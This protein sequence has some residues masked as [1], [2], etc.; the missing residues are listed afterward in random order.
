[1][2]KPVAIGLFGLGN[3]GSGLVSLLQERRKGIRDSTGL[4][5]SIKAICVKDTGKQRDAALS[6]EG[7]RITGD[8][9]AIVQDPDIDVAVELMGGVEPASEMIIKALQHKKPVVTANKAALAAKG[10]EIFTAASSNGVGIFFEAAVCG[11]IPIIRV[12]QESL[13]SDSIQAMFGIINGTTN[14]ILTKMTFDSKE[15]DAA[16]KEAQKLGFAEPDPAFD[17]L[18]NDAAQKL[19]ILASLG[20]QSRFA[21]KDVSTEGISSIKKKDIQYADRLGYRIKLLASAKRC[22]GVENTVSLRVA[23]TLIPKQHLLSGVL[24]ELNAI[25]LVG[26]YVGEQMY[27]GKG[28]GQYPTAAAVLSDVIFAAQHLTDAP[29]PFRNPFLGS[30]EIQDPLDGVS[31]FY[32]RCIVLDKPGVLAK[33]AGVLGTHGV[34]IA[35]FTQEERSA[36]GPVPI[37]LTTHEVS[38][39]QIHDAIKEIDALD[40]VKEKAVSLRIEDFS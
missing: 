27:Y 28:A 32:L 30:K 31:R 29:F 7:I 37:V 13:A 1:M 26:K 39:R 3:I 36:S 33:I 11:S 12:L 20:F 5:I 34:S 4:S 2:A 24:N 6:L 8:P 18:G 9:Q 19:S 40:V 16:L 21:E 17:V 38:E 10:D 35:S 23:P 25:F 14:Y 22:R 15:Y